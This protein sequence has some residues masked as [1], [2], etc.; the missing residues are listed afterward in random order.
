MTWKDLALASLFFAC[1]LGAADPALVLSEFIY[2]TAPFPSCHA[3]TITEAKDGHLVAAWFGG[4]GEKHPDVGIWISRL[5]GSQ[6]STP[7]E[8]ANGIQ[9]RKA[10]GAVVR[11]PTWNPVLFQPANGPLML[12]YKVGPSPQTWWGML[13][14]STDSGKTWE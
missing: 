12:F 1:P 9:Y 11:H 4:T 10:S 8:V 6:W 7:V 5:E 2:E 13:M 14:T 3:S